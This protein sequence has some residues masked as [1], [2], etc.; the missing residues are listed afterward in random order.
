MDFFHPYCGTNVRKLPLS[1]ERGVQ[2]HNQQCKRHEFP[3]YFGTIKWP[4][5]EKKTRIFHPR[6]PE[7]GQMGWILV[8]NRDPS[9]F[10]LTTNNRNI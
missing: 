1:K 9:G 3:Y 4:I 5:F 8:R 7:A 2:H 10:T 6:S